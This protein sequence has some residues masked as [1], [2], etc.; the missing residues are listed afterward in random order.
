M[1][2][3]PG[4]LVAPIS[5]SLPLAQT[6]AGICSKVAKKYRF[7]RIGEIRSKMETGDGD[8]KMSFTAMR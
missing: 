3:M 2:G 4:S 8:E 7:L 5:R 6:E 1:V